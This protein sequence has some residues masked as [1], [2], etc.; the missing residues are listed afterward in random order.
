MKIIKIILAVLNIPR[1]L[2]HIILYCRMA[3]GGEYLRI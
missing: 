2:P 1:L 3:G